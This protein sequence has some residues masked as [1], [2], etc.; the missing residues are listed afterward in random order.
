MA[1][2]H[3]GRLVAR[4]LKRHGATHLFTLC[5]GHIQSIYD[6][7]L[8]EGIAVIDVRHEQTAGHAADAYA[9]ISRRPGVCAVTA[10]PGV[11]DVVTA[12]ANAQRAGVPLV[13]IGGAG[14]VQLT[15][16]GSLQDMDAVALMGPITKAS[17]RVTETRRLEEYVDSAFRI[18]Q[19]GVPGPVFLE[20]PLDVLMNMAPESAVTAPEPPPRPGPDPDAL[21]KAAALLK[22]AE[23]PV[24]L[25]GSELRF[26]PA[27]DALRDLVLGVEAP[28]FVSGMARGALPAAEPC[29]FARAR[30]LALSSCD[31]LIAVGIPFDFRVDYGRSVAANAKIVHVGLDPD[32]LG[33]NKSADLRAF[34]AGSPP[35][36]TR[37]TSAG[38]R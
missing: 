1:N 37:R 19:A 29:F 12:V 26:S 28:V 3:G 4:A 23:R 2:F 5:G 14:P 10:G 21:E 30:K 32:S 34:R 11:T 25:I 20:L 35:Y 18:A 33:K 22:K 24:F 8:D 7:C 15:D 36:A 6:G 17:L 13:C 27:P 38:P 31:L 16:M 9:R